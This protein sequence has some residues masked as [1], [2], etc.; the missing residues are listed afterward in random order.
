MKALSADGPAI[1]IGPGHDAMICDRTGF[2]VSF[3]D[4]GRG[5]AYATDRNEILMVHRGHW[6]LAWNG[7]HVTLAPGDVCAV[8]RGLE[9]SLTPSRS[10][11]TALFRVRDTD[12][13][14]GPTRI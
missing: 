10:G 6:R 8:P 14:A 7:A 12:D 13:P 4:R 11:E 9:R 2:E 1:V 3:V 5:D